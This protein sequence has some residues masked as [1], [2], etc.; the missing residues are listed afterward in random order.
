[1]I[2]KEL[3]EELLEYNLDVK[4]EVVAHCKGY[5]F[6]LCC[7]GSEGCTKK[8]CDVVSLYVDELCSN[9]NIKEKE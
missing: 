9:E 6:S 2:V 5:N 1:M 3:I 4:I 7:G 8:T